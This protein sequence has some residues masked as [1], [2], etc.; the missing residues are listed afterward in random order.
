MENLNVLPLKSFDSATFRHL[1][2]AGAISNIF[3]FVS[4][5]L[6]YAVTI[7]QGVCQKRAFVKPV[8][9]TW[10]IGQHADSAIK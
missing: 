6:L 2:L 4:L 9:L 3:I 8:D 10:Y 1:P 5:L 7:R